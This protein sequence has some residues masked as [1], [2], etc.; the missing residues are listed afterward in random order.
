[1]PAIRCPAM[2]S[3]QAR[4]ARPFDPAELRRIKRVWVRHSIAEDRRDIEGLVATLA[5]G[6]VYE[7][8]ATSTRSS[9][10][11]GAGRDTRAPAPSTP[12]SSWRS[13]TMRSP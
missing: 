1:V 9:R 2:S 8:V 4:L 12:S 13:R 7:I 10:P 6:C 5:P 3:I 11:A